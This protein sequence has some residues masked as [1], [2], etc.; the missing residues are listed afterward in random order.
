MSTA[1]AAA[2]KKIAAFI[3]SDKQLRGKVLV[4]IGSIIAGLLGLMCL[5][6][7]V[8][9]SLGNMEFEPP[10]IDKSLFN[11]AAFIENLS[12]E[13]QAQLV[14]L[15]NQGQAIESA[16][17]NADCKNQTIKAQLIYLSF[18][19]GVQNFN[20][21]SYANIF[22]NSPDDKAI[23]DTL[24][25]T[26]GLKIDYSEF[27]KS[28][29]WVMNATI[30]GYMFEDSKSKNAADLAAWAENAYISGW[31]YKDG[32]FGDRDNTDRIR[33]VDG[34]GLILGYL[35]YDSEQKMFNSEPSSFHFT[36]KGSLDKMPDEAGNILSDGTNFGVYVGGAEVIFASEELGYV[37]K[38]KVAD[39]AWNSWSSI[40]GAAYNTDISFEEYDEKKKNNL[41]LVQWAIQ[42]HEAGWGYIYGTYG[43]VLTENLLQ[44]RAV[45]FGGE[46]TDYMDFIRQNWLGKR[47]ADCVGLIK[48]YSWYDS[49]SGEIRV[50]TNGMMDMGANAMFANATVKGTI[51]TI[52]EVPGLAVWVDGHIGIYIGNGEVIEAMNT[53]RGVTRTQLAG[54]EWTHWLQIPYISYVDQRDAEPM[55]NKSNQ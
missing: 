14:N 42:A 2:L 45:V 49:A 31:G 17:V 36:S 25:S 33:Y 26:Y 40:S 23:I 37:T 24:N 21:D 7:V 51:D 6:A 5:P 19:E 55:P 16:M 12:D 46:V 18:F 53:L 35:R 3:L 4:I 47:T 27:M 10:E 39:G 54:R 8:L 30:N 52:P 44:D 38:E 22:K 34:S 32:A 48:G 28:Y 29:T 15:Q 13:Q 1:V 11:E 20:V 43:N 9:L 41:G 50:G